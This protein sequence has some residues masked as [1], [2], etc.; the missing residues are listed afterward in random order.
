MNFGHRSFTSLLPTILILALAASPVLTADHEAFRVRTILILDQPVSQVLEGSIVKF[1]GKSVRADTRKGVASAI[2]KIFD[3]DIGFDDLM[4][5]G[6]LP[7]D[8]RHS[9]LSKDSKALDSP[10]EVGR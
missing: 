7:Q 5:S 3:S 8:L 4:A 10:I 1:T 6:T 9:K 2:I